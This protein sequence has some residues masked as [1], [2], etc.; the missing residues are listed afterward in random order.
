MTTCTCDN[1][2]HTCDEATLTPLSAAPGLDIRLEPGATVPAGECL[3]CGC[4][5]YIDPIGF[6]VLLSR[7]NDNWETDTYL[8]HVTAESP[9]AALAAAR[10][11]LNAV[12]EVDPPFNY[13]CLLLVAGTHDDLNP[14]I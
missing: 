12:D 13:T 8:C 9:A 5:S 3:E 6:T 10:A 11:E 7:E 4:F 2:G 1:C 14:E